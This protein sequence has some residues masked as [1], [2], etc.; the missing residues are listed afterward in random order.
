VQ[1]KVENRYLIVITKF[2]QTTKQGL[3]T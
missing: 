1:S 3:I 2:T